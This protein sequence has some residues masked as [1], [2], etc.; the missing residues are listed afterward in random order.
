MD[1]LLQHNLESQ[2]WNVKIELCKTIFIQQKYIG[3]PPYLWK[4]PVPKTARQY[5]I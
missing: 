4:Q 5:K 3:E 1:I 2:Y